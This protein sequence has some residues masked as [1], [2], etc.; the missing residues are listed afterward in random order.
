MLKLD[1]VANNTSK[2]RLPIMPS[3]KSESIAV[4]ALTAGSP[5]P[6]FD[7]TGDDGSRI[8]LAQFKGK[9]VVLYFYPKDDTPGCTAEAKDFSCLVGQFQAAGAVVIGVSPDSVASHAKFAK[10]HALTVRLGAD[11]DT[12]VAT[13]YGVWVE[14]S[15][16]G[17]TYMGVER[18]TFL[19][20]SSGK[21]E[22][23]WRK[24]KVAKHA[25]IVLA[26]VKALKTK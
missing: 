4:V 9:P 3:S 21:I 17:K 12:A 13:A 26:A 5:A 18:A 22:E 11:E 20:D 6:K 8:K 24:V 14:K 25:E 19:I 16:Y 15:M 23:V 7:M 10:K 1:E 2:E